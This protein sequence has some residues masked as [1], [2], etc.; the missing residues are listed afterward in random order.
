MLTYAFGKLG[1]QIDQVVD[2]AQ[3]PNK[4]VGNGITEGYE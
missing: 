2:S 4:S 1:I 3:S